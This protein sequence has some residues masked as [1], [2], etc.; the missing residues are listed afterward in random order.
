M[1]TWLPR[2]AAAAV[3][4]AVLLTAAAALAQLPSAEQGAFNAVDDAIS[5]FGSASGRDEMTRAAG[6]ILAAAERALNAFN[7]A[8]RA[9]DAAD[10]RVHAADEQA[11]AVRVNCDNGYNCGGDVSIVYFDGLEDAYARSFEAKSAISA[12]NASYVEAVGIA[13]AAEARERAARLRRFA[14]RMRG[15]GGGSSD[16]TRR[17]GELVRESNAENAPLNALDDRAAAAHVAANRAALDALGRAGRTLSTAAGRL[18]DGY[19]PATRAAEVTREAAALGFFPDVG[20][21]VR[22]AR[23]VQRSA[24]RTTLLLSKSVS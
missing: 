4:A 14:N 18:T 16:M 21:N 6:R 24:G 22:P 13:G 7:A 1:L 19:Y 8:D 3:G 12:A 20:S 23:S 15:L 17:M 2:P 11:N 5:A 10:A 9:R